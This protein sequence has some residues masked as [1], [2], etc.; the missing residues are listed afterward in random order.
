MSIFFPVISSKIS[1]TNVTTV[2]ITFLNEIKISDGNISIWEFRGSFSILR[3]SFSGNQSQYVQLFSNKT[4][5]ATVLSSTFNR[6]NSTYYVTIDNGFVKDAKVDQQLLGIKPT[7]WS[8]TTDFPLE[9]I[10]DDGKMLICVWTLM[11]FHKVQCALIGINRLYPFTDTEKKHYA[12]AIIRFTPEGSTF[13][14]NLS[15]QDQIKFSTDFSRQLASII[16]CDP[17]RISTTKKYQ[18]DR[19]VST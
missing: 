10:K 14:E 6:E 8:F 5:V 9:N 17:E 4:V 13:Y 16:P 1:P 15:S 18:Y 19:S 12:S 3:Q 11:M 2:T 7:L